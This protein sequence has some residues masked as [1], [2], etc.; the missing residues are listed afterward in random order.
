MK[1]LG[2]LSV[3]T[4]HRMWSLRR[5]RNVVHKG[6]IEKAEKHIEENE[7]EARQLHRAMHR[8]CPFCQGD[9]TVSV[10]DNFYENGRHL[11]PCPYKLE[12]LLGS[13]ERPDGWKARCCKGL[14][15]F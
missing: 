11:E 4:L 14:R 1:D 12:W 3:K 13:E 10:R 5:E 7:E 2:K 9:G 15:P 6:A 8:D